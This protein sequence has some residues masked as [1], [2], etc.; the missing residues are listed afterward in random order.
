MHAQDARIHSACHA[1]LLQNTSI[2]LSKSL[3]AAI[4]RGADL[5]EILAQSVG[6]ASL[7][8]A[9]TTVRCH[10]SE[11]RGLLAKVPAVVREMAGEDRPMPPADSLRRHLQPAPPEG[12]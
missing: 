11:V 3:N 9:H 1:S 5:R 12:S 6:R 10:H 2:Q 7:D 4:E 8:L